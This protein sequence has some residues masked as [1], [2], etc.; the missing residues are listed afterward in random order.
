V[1]K[2]K[3]MTVMDTDALAALA[4]SGLVSRRT[5]V[6]AHIGWLDNPASTPEWVDVACAAL[7]LMEQKGWAASERIIRIP[8]TVSMVPL[9]AVE[10]PD[11]EYGL[12]VI[13]AIITFGLEPYLPTHVGWLMGSQVQQQHKA[14]ALVA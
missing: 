4:S 2:K 3:N 6:T 11:G 1:G 7:H 8:P 13:D 10:L 14:T 9:A 12:S 5:A